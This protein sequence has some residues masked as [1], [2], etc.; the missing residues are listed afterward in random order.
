MGRHEIEYGA[1]R[2]LVFED[3]DI[4]NH[5]RKAL[6]IKIDDYIRGNVRADTLVGYDLAQR[7]RRI[8]KVAIEICKSYAPT[9]NYGI[10]KAEIRTAIDHIFKL[11]EAEY[12][13][14]SHGD[15]ATIEASAL[16]E[17][18]K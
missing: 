6:Y 8:E 13:V 15:N 16:G 7:C 11:M 10:K 12:H 14:Q 1:K 17:A 18:G 2:P 4:R 5:W 9:R 3:Y